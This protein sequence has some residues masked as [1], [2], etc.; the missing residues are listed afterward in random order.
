MG[1]LV[2]LV[3][4]SVA[5]DT[6]TGKHLSNPEAFSDQP[7]EVGGPPVLQKTLSIFWLCR[8]LALYRGRKA[9]R[10]TE[11]HKRH[12]DLSPGEQEETVQSSPKGI[13]S[14]LYP[15]QQALS[16]GDK[17]SQEGRGGGREASKPGEDTLFLPFHCCL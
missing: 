2:L 4:D 17:E 11:G 6:K 16:Q 9:T 12:G 14:L 7:S 13:Y 10:D 1:D 8:A 5:S 3:P 15:S